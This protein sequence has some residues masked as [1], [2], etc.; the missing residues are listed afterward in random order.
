MEEFLKTV[1]KHYKDK[2]CREAQL[3]GEP[4]SLPLS[5]YLFCFPN[6]RSGLFFA[7]HLQEV[8][9][10]G[11]VGGHK[12]PCCVPPITTIS[13]LFGIFSTR[14]V[15]DR[16]ALLFRLFKIYD[17]LSRR[18]ERE[19]FDQFVFWGDMLLS[20]FDDVDKYLVDADQLFSNVRDLKEIE[21]R[22]AGFTEEQIQ[23]IK[24]FWLSFR[25]EEDY[26]EGDKHE[27][28]GQ[29]WAILA[30]LY[31]AFKQDLQK[32]NLAYEG[33]M[34]REVIEL[35]RQEKNQK[36]DAESLEDGPE[37]IFAKLHYDKVV[38]VGL[39]AVSE[40]DRQ[41]MSMLKFRGKAEFCWDYADPRIYSK[42]SRATSASYFTRSN[43]SDFGNEISEE[44]LQR[45]LV[46]ETERQVT[47]YSV[48]SGVGQTQ[49][50]RRILLHWQNSVEGFDP[51][52]TAVVLPDEKL[53]LPMLYAVPSSLDAF[54]VTMGYS[55]RSTPVAAFVTMLAALQ[56]SWREHEKSFYFRQVL[57]LLAHSFTLGVSG[58][59][60]REITK[61]ITSQNRYKVT[62]D[63]FANDEF[64]SL[65]FRPLHT[66]D[67]TIAYIDAIL[68][69]LMQVAARDIAK[70]KEAEVDENGQMDLSFD[71]AEEDPSP[72]L[73]IFGETDYE[74]LYHYRK[75]LL[76]LDKEVRK[77]DLVF[78]PKTLFLLLEKLVAGV[79]VPF[80]GEPLKGLQLMGVLE[81][82][83]LDFDNVIILSMNEGVFPAKPVQNTFVPMSLRDAFGMPTQKHRDSVFA[84]HFYR[85][86]GRAKR[87][88][89]IYD[90]RTD[91]MQTGEESRY[92]KQL[93]FLMGH[94]NLKTQ[95][96][97]DDIGM[98]DAPK[99]VV[100]K[101]PEVMQLLGKCLSP[102]GTRNF[103]ATVLKD[104]ITCPL[105]FYL[106][107]V[108]QLSE[109][110]EVSEGVDAAIFGDILHQAL[111]DLYGPGKGRRIEASM[112]DKLIDKN[113]PDITKAI[114]EAFVK[115]M[116]MKPDEDGKVPELEGYNLLVSQIL[117]NYIRETLR[118]DKELCPFVYLAGETPQEFVFKASDDLFVRI[119]CIYDRLDR[120]VI[121]NAKGTVRIVDYK[122]GNSGRGAKLNFPEIEDFFIEDGKGSKEAFQVMLYCLL[123]ENA[124][125]KDLCR[126]NLKET[127]GSIVPHLYF[128]RDF[129]QHSK[130]ST[131][132]SEGS[133]KN[134]TPLQDFTP[135]RDEF[136]QRLINLFKEIYNPEVPF[137]QCEDTKSCTWCTF[138]NLCNRI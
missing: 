134:A 12:A 55:L 121:N 128:V 82:R 114:N 11:Q 33:M 104:Y 99:F 1:A 49:Q 36:S 41:L 57:P 60:A 62:L 65:I 7:R 103:S 127:P 13:E 109:D 107:F 122:T 56:Q 17:S 112:L 136:R 125:S 47:L 95:T 118:H 32:Q 51:F 58:E 98:V 63:T 50:A 53:L 44:E 71:E 91:G 31:H 21:A 106:S 4:S 6:R 100:R 46:P 94:S 69:K 108:R 5:R 105:K 137:K 129:H 83:A 76:Q 67:E 43:L 74:F 115:V 80:S 24:S 28:F 124:T 86:I 75:T 52:R 54:N 26:P 138:A 81:T 3:T 18:R 64:L 119:K 88:A 135:Y 126:F 77:H 93:R 68:D 15:I 48:S 97:T 45:G 90:S 25:P 40:V 29:T 73:N 61:T 19:T 8:F 89:M 117:I 92:V 72:K 9:D 111:R 101:S 116:K 2:S 38:F 39:T 70:E 35:L 10:N 87:L 20:D 132:L 27:V 22:F 59:S 110:D 79:S 131:V 42:D 130:C 14:H 37:G 23:V 85:L 84:Y 66:V 123:L 78:T 30:E 120:P 34:E 102:N 113:S 96:V 16:T 133:G